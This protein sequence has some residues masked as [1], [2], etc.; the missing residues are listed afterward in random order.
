MR[1]D[2]R[3]NK[4]KYY[5]TVKTNRDKLIRKGEIGDWKNYFSKRQEHDIMS[6]ELDDVTFLFRFFYYIFFTLRRR[7]F[8]IE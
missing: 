7:L 1:N 4:S 8:K 3:M 6:I 2:L 5:S